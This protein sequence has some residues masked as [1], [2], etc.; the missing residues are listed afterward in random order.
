MI[1][2]NNHY[3]AKQIRKNIRLNLGAAKDPVYR[4]ALVTK[5]ILQIR[6][7][8]LVWDWD[9]PENEIKNYPQDKWIKANNDLNV[10]NTALQIGANLLGMNILHLRKICDVVFD[11]YF[12]ENCCQFFMP[13][14]RDLCV[15]F[16]VMN[17]KAF[18]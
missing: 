17:L 15:A 3:T 5:D 11:T 13:P 1:T 16:R 18:K 14:T 9:K 8:E 4:L 6:N 12:D 10:E 7:M 2:R